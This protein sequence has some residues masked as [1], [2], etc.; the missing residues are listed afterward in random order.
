MSL[1]AV[2]GVMLGAF[3]ITLGVFAYVWHGDD[4]D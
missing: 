3:F 4:S 1:A 2:L